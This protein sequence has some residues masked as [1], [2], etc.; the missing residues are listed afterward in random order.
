MIEFEHILSH[1]EN[2]YTKEKSLRNKILLEGALNS[3]K[4]YDKAI[5][6]DEA[7]FIQ[8]TSF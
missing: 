3:L 7:T 6:Q 2:L 5:N 1:L 8:R 4:E